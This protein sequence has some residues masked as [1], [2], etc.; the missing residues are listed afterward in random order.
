MNIDLADDP[1]LIFPLTLTNQHDKTNN[2]IFQIIEKH[3]ARPELIFVDGCKHVQRLNLR[4][5]FLIV[6]YYIKI[7]I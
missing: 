6:Y 4:E 1:Y 5:E 2:H 7:V 3:D